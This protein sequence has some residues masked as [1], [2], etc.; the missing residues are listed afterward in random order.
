M[1]YTRKLKRKINR[2]KT[3]KQLGG[4]YCGPANEI[5]TIHR[6]TKYWY[7]T[8]GRDA[9][10]SQGQNGYYYTNREGCKECYQSPIHTHIVFIED[11][12]GDT[13]GLKKITWSTKKAN[14]R[15]GTVQL[16]SGVDEMMYKSI[17]A[18]LIEKNNS[19]DANFTCS[20][21]V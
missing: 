13:D 14:G 17:E 9:F 2:K 18:W 20:G 4:G 3:R 12:D 6:F 16:G 21:K 15:G 8:L 10:W 19:V 5:G 11:L 1:R 7:N